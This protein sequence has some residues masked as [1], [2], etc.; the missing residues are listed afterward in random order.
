M[1]AIV[2]FANVALPV[3]ALREMASICSLPYSDSVELRSVQLGFLPFSV[4]RLSWLY[5]TP[6]PLRQRQ[7][8]KAEA[9]PRRELMRT[10]NM[11]VR[12]GRL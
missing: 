3:S 2:L 4:A 5:G 10:C 1:T 9:A 8:A 11:R 6:A 12:L 7:S